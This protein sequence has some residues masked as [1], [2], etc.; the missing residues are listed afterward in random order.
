MTRTQRA[1]RSPG[2]ATAASKARSPA[3][4]NAAP[5]STKDRSSVLG[6]FLAERARWINGKSSLSAHWLSMNDGGTKA[7][8]EGHLL[9]EVSFIT[10]TEGVDELL[11]VLDQLALDVP[12]LRDE[13]WVQ[14]SCDVGRTLDMISRG[15]G[16]LDAVTA[17]PQ[18]QSRADGNGGRLDLTGAMISRAGGSS[19]ASPPSL[20]GV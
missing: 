1:T 3:K 9:G 11:A 13:G 8:D 12:T 20:R 10:L 4:R 6:A 5:R 16:G 19:K 18:R 15:G 7:A 2:W 17:P 14:K